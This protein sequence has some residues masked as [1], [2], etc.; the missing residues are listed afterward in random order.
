MRLRLHPLIVPN[1]H[2]DV[3]AA[4]RDCE[5]LPGRDP[6]EELRQVGSCICEAE[7]FRAKNCTVLYRTAAGARTRR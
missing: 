4:T 7:V 3:R 6:I 2:C 1:E 5:R